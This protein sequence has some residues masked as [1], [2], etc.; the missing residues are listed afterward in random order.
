MP[1][2]A[3]APLAISRQDQ[4]MPQPAITRASA[5]AWPL[6][7]SWRASAR[8]VSTSPKTT[9]P[10]PRAASRNLGAAWVAPF[11]TAY[12]IRQPDAAKLRSSQLLDE[13]F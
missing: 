11:F 8:T 13:F 7:R 6:R 2:L 3:T 5:G 9:W 4:I 12:G 10:R 1:M